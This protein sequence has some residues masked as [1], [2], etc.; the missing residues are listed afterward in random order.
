MFSVV[1]SDRKSLRPGQRLHA[2]MISVPQNDLRHMGHVGHDGVM[3]GDVSCLDQKQ[4]RWLSKGF[5]LSYNYALLQ[6]NP[7]K[8][9]DVECTNKETTI[10]NGNI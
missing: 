7:F 3:F 1:E 5:H 4:E 2:G 6:L 8:V 9:K 10:Y